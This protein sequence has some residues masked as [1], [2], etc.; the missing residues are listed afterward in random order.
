M[1]PVNNSME[2]TIIIPNHSHPQLSLNHLTS[3]AITVI[4]SLGDGFSSRREKLKSLS[5][6][7]REERFHLAVLGQFKRGKSTLLNALLGENVLPTSVI[8]VTAIPTFLLP[9]PNPTA[10]IYF[11]KE[12]ASQTY[13][14]QDGH[15]LVDYLSQFVTEE[16]NPE[17]RLGVTYVEVHFPSP[18][19]EKVVLIDTPGIGSTFRHNTEATLNFL[20]QCDAAL[21]L[22]SADPPITETELDF[23]NQVKG[24]VANLFFILNK[25]DYL[26]LEEK[27]KALQFYRKVLSQQFSGD[28][29]IQIFCVSARQGLMARQKGDETLW[30]Q[31]GMREVENHLLQFLAHDKE[32]ALQRAIAAK[33]GVI[34]DDVLLQLSLAKRSMELPIEELQTR[35]GLFKGK[36]KEAER[37]K[38]IAGDLLAGDRKR[39]EAFLEEQASALRKKARAHLEEVMRQGLSQ[40]PAS[41]TLEKSIE[42]RLAQ[43]VP[44]FFEREL[45]AVARTFE[46]RVEEV[47]RPHQKQIQQLVDF[48]R[49]YAA[50]LFEIP[51]IA[52]QEE[53]PFKMQKHP[54]WVTHEWSSTAT[55]IPAGAFDPLLP[56]RWRRARMIKRLTELI[57]TLVRHNV[58]NLRWATLQN[59]EKAFYRF[60]AELTEQLQEAI[61]ATHGAVQASLR[62]RREH[63]E[64]V[65]QELE[66]MS[67]ARSALDGLKQQLIS[68]G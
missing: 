31:S 34:I 32:E 8:P 49:K 68:T 47:L 54:Y 36:L 15:L 40:P 55:P 42:L 3:Q 16:G 9:G 43:A 51:H 60:E 26:S 39:T 58:E 28:Q 57:H 24:R 5:E 62:L 4:D 11:Q 19:L 66:R 64:K 53:A 35:M 13:T 46:K 63:S 56:A 18:L 52:A 67:A 50:N 44:T 20:P 2:E 21:F 61:A 37:Q 38:L 41:G 17:N 10:S 7:L 59:L 45:G 27:E 65:A 6:R 30:R 48:V 33:V 22:V 29:D 12:T 1:S 23:L 14:E 25:V